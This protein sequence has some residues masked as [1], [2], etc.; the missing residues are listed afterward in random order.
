MKAEFI[1]PQAPWSEYDQVL[2]AQGE[3][4]NSEVVA[5][6]SVAVDDG[7]VARVDILASAGESC[8]RSLRSIDSNIYIGFGRFVFV[9]DVYRSHVRRHPLSGYFGHLY[10]SHDLEHLDGYISALAASASEVLAFDR[11]GGLIWKQSD[12]GLDG[13]VLHRASKGR[14][15]GEGEWD[16][17]GGWRPFGLRSETGLISDDRFGSLAAGRDDP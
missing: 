14:I 15:D 9:V 7:L 8:F 3:I 2:I 13:V 10:D 16:P 12:L 5:S 17:P 6:V 1:S 11:A 4:S